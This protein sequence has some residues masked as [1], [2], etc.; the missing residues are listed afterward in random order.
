MAPFLNLANALWCAAG[1][2]ARGVAWSRIHDALVA[3]AGEIDRALHG[4]IRHGARLVRS[5]SLVLTYSHSTA[6]RMVLLRALAA[7]RRFEVVCSE[8]RPTREGLVLAKQLADA[9]IPVHLVV[10]AALPEWVEKAE[11]VLVGADAV[12]REGIVNK[13]GT[14]PLLCASRR[15]RIPAFALADSHKWLPPQLQAFWC[16]RDESPRGITTRPHRNL[17]VHNRYFDVTPHKL[18]SG[19]VWEGGICPPHEARQM[20]ARLPVA[21]T[22]LSVLRRRSK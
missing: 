21:A 14:R 9:G 2:P 10:D 4:T 16:V 1:D 7:G 15:S 13:I 3:H 17:H 19:V 22:L 18:F 11:L 8:S 6:V 5:G 12:V 20:T